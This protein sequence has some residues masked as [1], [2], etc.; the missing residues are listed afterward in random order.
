MSNSEKDRSELKGLPEPEFRKKKRR[1]SIVWL[2]PLVALA[3]GGWLVYKAFSEKGPTITIAFKSAAGLEAGKTKIKYKEVELGQV[4]SIDLD[5][6]LQGVILKAELVKKAEQFLSQ[7]TRFW[8]VRARVAAGGVSGLGTLFSGA[9][10]GLDPGKPGPPATHFQGLEMP[11]VVTTDLPGSHF[12]LRAASL[13]SL[14]IGDPVYFRR[15]EVGQVVSYKLDEDGQAVTLE[16]FVHDPHHKL[17]RKNTRFWNASGLDVAISADGI[18]VDTESLVTLMIGGIAF[19]TPAGQLPADPAAEH[20]V[21]QLYKN[22]ESIS[23]KTYT[24]KNQWLL[25]FDGG[26][27]GLKSGAPVEIQG[28]QVGQ[29]LDVNLEFD[30]EKEAFSIPV[31]IE[32]E[33][34]RIRSTG[35]MPEGA[36]SQRIMDYLV[37][38][39]MRAQLKTGSLI[40][41]QLLVTIDMHP[42]APPAKINWDGVY[43]ELPTVPTAMEEITTSL[44]QLLKKL[45]KLP[46]EQ[47]GYDLRDTVSGAKRLVNSPELQESAAAL[48]DTLNQAQKFVAALNAGVAP[49]LKT[50]VSNLNA[51]LIQAQKLSR[52][53]NSNVAPQADRTLKELQSA[54]R[55]IK[56]WA[57][58]LER[59]PEAL[60]RG[61]SRSKRR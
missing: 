35:K 19:D 49:E 18:R 16:V 40:T 33:P 58:Y 38:K 25:Y 26:V 3:V 8:V 31:L 51:A 22:R 50:A 14:N 56:I 53:L 29:V 45:E 43:P 32:T 57:E 15:I 59:H 48:N 60:I 23:E 54:A 6:S 42:E 47:I 10:I 41:G 24:R 21:F 12:V 1:I 5:D 13:G 7:N 55:S 4:A 46:I 27:R 44:T 52:S 28:I 34:D 61:K 20:D 37:A 30:V 36:E 17:V 11:P 39:G 9:Y 2:V